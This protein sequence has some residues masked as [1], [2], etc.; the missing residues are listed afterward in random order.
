MC[1]R[2]LEE[3]IYGLGDK[4]F[5]PLIQRR[6]CYAENNRLR[7]MGDSLKGEREERA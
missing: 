4:T 2:I 3:A 1:D 5:R 7:Q 6:S